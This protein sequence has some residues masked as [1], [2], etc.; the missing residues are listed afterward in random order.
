[1]VK[2]DIT[3]ILPK[4]I[5]HYN[6]PYADSSAIP[7]YYVSKL[8]RGKVTVALNGDGGDESFAGYERY[9]ADRLA[10]IYQYIP[11][12]LREDII[13]KLVYL[14]FPFNPRY[15][16]FSRRLRRFLD[17]ISIEKERRYV[18]W[19]CFFKNNQK[20]EI[21]QDDFKRKIGLYDSV[22]LTVKL[23][24]ECH[25]SSFLDK[26]LFV[27]L[28]S[29]LPDDLLVKVDIAS[30]AH[31]LETRSPFLDHKLVE[32][33]ASLPPWLKLKKLK[34]KYLLK[35]AFSGLLPKEILK[36][37]KMGFGVPLDYWFR[38][39]LKEFM[40]D[41]LLGKRFIERG[42]FKK[43]KIKKLLNE[44]VKGQADHSY[45]IWAL[46]VLELWHQMFV[47]KTLKP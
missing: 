34:G 15:K 43:E 12:F 13:K 26:T 40:Y 9:I 16:S 32:F 38:G 35:K 6:E 29:Y 27:D 18:E 11:S 8:T 31:S 44:H 17:S 37:K 10:N 4:L 41:I 24:K 7:T 30:M 19:L 22:D 5:W 25:V 47:D 33:A 1:V 14:V 42:Y 39:E 36:R 20:D 45:R 21:Y 46:L 2:P 28:N 3:A 23:F